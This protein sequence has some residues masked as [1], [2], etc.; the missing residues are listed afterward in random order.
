MLVFSQKIRNGRSITTILHHK[1]SETTFHEIDNLDTKTIDEAQDNYEKVF[2]TVRDALSKNQQ[3]FCVEENDRLSLVQVVT[4]LL[5]QEGLIS[6]E[7][8]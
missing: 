4:D 3:Y 8:K 2:V 1:Y 7:S 5:R 6:R